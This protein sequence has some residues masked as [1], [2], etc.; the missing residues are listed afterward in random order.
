MGKNPIKKMD[1]VPASINKNKNIGNTK[2]KKVTKNLEDQQ[3]ICIN[4][5]QIKSSTHQSINKVKTLASDHFSASFDGVKNSK[6][7]LTNE[8]VK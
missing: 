2:S 6:N 4:I 3:D 5:K 1:T 7:I 8:K